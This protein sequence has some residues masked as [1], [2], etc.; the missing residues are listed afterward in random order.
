LQLQYLNEVYIAYLNQVNVGTS[1]T[2]N[3]SYWALIRVHTCAEVTCVAGAKK[4]EWP[5]QTEQ[6]CLVSG[7]E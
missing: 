4:V 1:G 7:T 5:V 2:L 6:I 3:R